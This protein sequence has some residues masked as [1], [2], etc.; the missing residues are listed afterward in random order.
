MESQNK[1][2]VGIDLGT[3]YSCV[4][5][6]EKNQAVVIPNKQ[7]FSLTPSIV[8]FTPAGKVVGETARLQLAIDPS[9]TI[10][11]VK[12][13]IGLPF[14]SELVQEDIKKYLPFKIEADLNA[15][16]EKESDRRILI[17]VT[18]EE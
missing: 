13:I 3:T 16:V 5:V 1:K 18:E 4:A 11:D 14:S 9:N 15:K 6:F 7:G 2:A 17:R 12:R 10:Y 8:A